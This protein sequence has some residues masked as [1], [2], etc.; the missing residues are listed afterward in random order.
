[1]AGACIAQF[2]L[3]ERTTDAERWRFD[4]GAILVARALGELTRLRRAWTG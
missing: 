2:R 1:M 4:A 3:G